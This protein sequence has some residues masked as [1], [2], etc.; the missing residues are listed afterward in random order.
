MPPHR[1]QA[2]RIGS[3]VFIISLHQSGISPLPLQQGQI[4]NLI[5]LVTYSETL[6]GSPAAPLKYPVLAPVVLP[7]PA[8]LLPYGR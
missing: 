1:E 7:V 8:F 4:H 3:S 6:E 2:T 5:S